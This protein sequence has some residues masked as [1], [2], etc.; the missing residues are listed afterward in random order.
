[1]HFGKSEYQEKN[2][3]PD[4]CLLD[5]LSICER[6]IDIYSVGFK[7]ADGDERPLNRDEDVMA[8]LKEHEDIMTVHVYLDENETTQPLSFKIPRDNP[9]LGSFNL[10]F[11]LFKIYLHIAISFDVDLFLNTYRF[12]YSIKSKSIK[13]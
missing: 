10:S 11:M 1:M 2:F 6:F 5:I 12:I 9:N 8:M 13:C 7:L 4:S 3:S